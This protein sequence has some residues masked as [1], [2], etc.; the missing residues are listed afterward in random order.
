MRQILFEY[1]QLDAKRATPDAD[2]LRGWS[3]AYLSN[4]PVLGAADH[5]TDKHPLN[6]EAVPLIARLFPQSIIVHVRRDPLETCLSIYRQEFNKHWAFAHRLEDIGHF[7]GHYARLVAHWERKFP[8]R[9]VTVQYESFAADFENAAPT[10]LKQ[11]GLAWESAC[12]DFQKAPRAIATFSAVQARG[13][14]TVANGRALR[15]ANHLAPLRQ[16]L[17]R[18][19]VDLET[20]ALR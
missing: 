16:E 4:L 12:L 2:V 10:L 13:P 6:F 7:Y 5:I 20:G 14:V 17:E 8:D 1:L 18:A 11:C 15:Y 3:A 9:F 19:N